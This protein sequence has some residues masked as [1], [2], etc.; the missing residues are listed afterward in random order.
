MA[1][2]LYLDRLRYQKSGFR[3][4][5][6]K[7]VYVFRRGVALP[8]AGPLDTRAKAEGERKRM[9]E[10]QGGGAD[11]SKTGGGASD[12]AKRTGT[13]RG[14]DPSDSRSADHATD[15]KSPAP[16]SDPGKGTTDSTE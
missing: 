3:V 14:G 8:V 9:T 10:K 6:S 1:G 15:S 7:H 11:T 13:E 4:R 5:I 12:T 16:S 2:D